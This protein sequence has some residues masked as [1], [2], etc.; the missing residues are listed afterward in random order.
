M[1]A[2]Q[3]NS[4]NSLSCTMQACSLPHCCWLSPEAHF[5]IYR[6]VCMVLHQMHLEPCRMR[7]PILHR[8]CRLWTSLAWYIMRS[9]AS[10]R[11]RLLILMPQNSINHTNPGILCMAA[12][13]LLAYTR[14]CL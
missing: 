3:H 5:L 8:A 1:F 7:L 11:V 9:P 14:K 6:S 10:F 13:L 4:N 2:M 12:W